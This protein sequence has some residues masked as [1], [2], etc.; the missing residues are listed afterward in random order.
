VARPAIGDDQV[1][2][3]VHAAGMG[4]NVGH[5]LT[6][7]PYVARLGLGLR[8]PK[9]RLLR[10]DIAGTLE[11]VGR[12]AAGFHPGDAVYGVSEGGLAEYAP[13]RVE[14]LA[15]KPTNLS[16]VEAAAVPVP[17]SACAALHG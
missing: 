8:R 10:C 6:G 4:P 13:A 9:D 15:P 17:V 1:L 5:A 16:F 12:D 7:V 2:V 3:R 11:A 14:E